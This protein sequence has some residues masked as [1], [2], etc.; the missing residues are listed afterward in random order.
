MEAWVVRPSI[1]MVSP[2]WR[3]DK[4]G[5][6]PRGQSKAHYISSACKLYH[7]HHHR[8]R[9]KA[10]PAAY[11]ISF[12]AVSISCHVEKGQHAAKKASKSSPKGSHLIAAQDSHRIHTVFLLDQV[13]TLQSLRLTG[14]TIF[15]VSL[16]IRPSNSAPSNDMCWN[17]VHSA[18]RL[19]VK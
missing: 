2:L 7:H 13:D 4:W 5:I 18:V 6:I 11:L 8:A 1:S 16:W 14:N 17:R 15:A 19:V 3:I 9:L 10:P 12:G